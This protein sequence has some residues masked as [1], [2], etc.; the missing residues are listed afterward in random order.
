MKYVNLYLF[1]E[2][3]AI[4]ISDS[5][6]C[7]LSRKEKGPFALEW[8]KTRQKGVTAMYSP[9]SGVPLGVLFRVPLFAILTFGLLVGLG[10][11]KVPFEGDFPAASIV[12]SFDDGWESVYTKAFPVFQRCQAVGTVFVVVE[13][14]GLPGFLSWEQLSTL[15]QNHWEIGIKSGVELIGLSDETLQKEIV[16]AKEILVQ[17]GFQVVSFASRNNRYDER[18]LSLIREHYLGHRTTIPGINYRPF[19]VF[20]MKAFDVWEEGLNL[21]QIFSLIKDTKE[22]KGHLI[23]VFHKID[24]EGPESFPSWKLEAVCQYAKSQGFRLFELSSLK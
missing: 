23:L 11:G 20:E 1:F 22:T 14:V 5:L 8:S 18:V 13:K 16:E 2:A 24:E 19:N 7:R 6:F 17:K 4:E 12:F 15:Q 3:L 9:I 10:L 21:D